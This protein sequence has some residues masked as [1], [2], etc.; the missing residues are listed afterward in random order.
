MTYK[1][2]FKEYLENYLEYKIKL[3]YKER[4]YISFLKVWDAYV[5][6]NENVLC[7]SKE[8]VDAFI[9]SKH[10]CNP[11]T[12]NGYICDL[13]S[14]SNYLNRFETD[15]FIVPLKYYKCNRY[16]GYI[17]HIYTDE[18]FITIIKYVKEYKG[19]MYR[20]VDLEIIFNLL[21]GTGMRISEVLNL[22]SKNI[23]LNTGEI[24]IE[25]SKNDKSRYVYLSLNMNKRI[26]N[27]YVAS[28]VLVKSDYFV[29]KGDGTKCNINMLDTIFNRLLKKTNREF[30]IKPRIHDFRHTFAVNS[31]NDWI[32]QEKPVMELLPILQIYL[33][34]ADIKS[35]TYY[36]RLLPTMFSTIEEKTLSKLEYIIPNT[37]SG[38]IYES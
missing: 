12:I 22:K 24:F 19:E 18:E 5:L 7:F 6:E 37:I 30:D 17:P 34:H 27:L 29:K 23:N 26:R 21:Y 1:S 32:L 33:G 11:S 4:T 36:L 14:F 10:H 38:D 35:T 28:V 15:V 20:S 16:N 8:L 2:I 9:R 13:R 31:L 3:G 25:N